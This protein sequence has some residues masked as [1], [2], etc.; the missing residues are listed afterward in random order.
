V[1]YYF[2]F[3]EMEKARNSAETWT[4][5]NLSRGI[6]T[7]CDYESSWH[8]QIDRLHNILA[9]FTPWPTTS[10]P[11][12]ATDPNGFTVGLSFHNVIVEMP[13]K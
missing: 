3:L 2:D 5:K 1:F 13:C 9:L 7:H 12:Y 8:R 11:K 10:N 4:R 6:S